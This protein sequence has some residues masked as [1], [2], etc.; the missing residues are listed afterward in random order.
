MAWLLP[1][2]QPSSIMAFQIRE[3]QVERIKHSISRVIPTAIHSA[4]WEKSTAGTVTMTGRNPQHPGP[5]PGVRRMISRYAEE[6][7]VFPFGDHIRK[8]RGGQ[9][10]ADTID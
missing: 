10:S 8:S 1:Q 6:N 9:D 4:K 7:T 2:D 5:R 3:T